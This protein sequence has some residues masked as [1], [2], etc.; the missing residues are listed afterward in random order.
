MADSIA[1]TRAVL[2]ALPLCAVCLAT[3]SKLISTFTYM[4]TLAACIARA[5]VQRYQCDSLWSQL[6]LRLYRIWVWVHQLAPVEPLYLSLSPS[7]HW[8]WVMLCFSSLSLFNLLAR[9]WFQT[10]ETLAII[11]QLCVKV[12]PSLKE[13]RWAE[14]A[15]SIAVVW[16]MSIIAVI[17][18]MIARKM[19]NA[20]YGMDDTLIVVGLVSNNPAEHPIS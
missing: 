18:R 17:L 1:K 19:S 9:N 14:A 13:S 6:W 4:L 11:P 12:V 5:C 2:A 3:T 8:R 20:K 10:I 16:T 15:A 7:G